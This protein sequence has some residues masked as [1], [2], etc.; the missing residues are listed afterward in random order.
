MVGES[1]A[2][3][4]VR[5]LVDVLGATTLSVLILGETGSGKELVAQALHHRS[6][7]SGRFVP[8]NVC[9]IGDTM[10][11]DSFFGHVR[12]AY[13]GAISDRPGFFAES[14]HGTI[15]LDEIG[16]LQLQAQSKL[17]RP[18]ETREF[19]PVGDRRDHR[20]DFRV[21]AAT[22]QM[23][24]DRVSGGLF[25]S[26]LAYRLQDGLIHVPPLRDRRQDIASLARHFVMLSLPNGT[27]PIHLAA[28]AI[29][30]LE[31]YSWPGNVRELRQ[32]IRRAVAF[33]DAPAIGLA[34]LERAWLWTEGAMGPPRRHVAVHDQLDLGARRLLDALERSDWD[35]VKVADELGVTRKTVYARLARL[36][37]PLPRRYRWRTAHD[38]ACDDAATLRVAGEIH[39]ESVNIHRES[40]EAS[41]NTGGEVTTRY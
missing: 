37:I 8:V 26:D 27:E 24:A 29:R 10:F 39:R 19:R 32:V 17:L 16:D 2:I 33:A 12:G 40:R 41:A 5:D 30:A 28:E 11:E 18:L 38:V 14:D 6:G 23:I 4:K 31:A 35:T 7:R 21:V 3:Q 1:R 20:S 9:A 34:Q 13:T 15:F 25:R 22:N 36:G